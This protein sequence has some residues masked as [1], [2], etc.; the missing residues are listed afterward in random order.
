M[1][2][3]VCDTG[4]LDGSHR[5]GF[6]AAP[7]NCQLGL[8][9]G[10]PT[11]Y[12]APRLRR[13]PSPGVSPSTVLAKRPLA[14][15]GAL[16]WRNNQSFRPANGSDI[17]TSNSPPSLSPPHKIQ[18]AQWGSATFSPREGSPLPRTASVQGLGSTAADVVL[19][20]VVR[21]TGRLAESLH[22]TGVAEPAAESITPID[23]PPAT[24][25]YRRLFRSVW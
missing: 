13:S 20:P 2:V 7:L 5:I 4:V 23:G 21:Q 1:Q 10:S 22:E 12:V 17:P 11:K 9:T 19:A 24:P 3:Q 16:L 8:L 6:D 14:A 25:A 15:D 18:V